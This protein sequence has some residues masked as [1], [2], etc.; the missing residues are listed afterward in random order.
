MVDAAHQVVV[1]RKS[2]LWWY[3][4]LAISALICLALVLAL[5]GDLHYSARQM[6]LM[7]KV[8]RQPGKRVYMVQ[9]FVFDLP[10]YAGLDRPVRVIDD[11]R[12]PDIGQRDNWRRELFD[13]GV[14]NPAPASRLLLTPEDLPA[15]LCRNSTSW[16]IGNAKALGNLCIKHLAQ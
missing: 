3:A 6:G 2:R 8:Q 14:F 4:S 1:S 9:E 16:L 15:V 13:A 5:T 11:W 10:F 12:N 7:L